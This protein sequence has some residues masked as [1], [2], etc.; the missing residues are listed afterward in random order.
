ML[1]HRQDDGLFLDRTRPTRHGAS[2][3]PKPTA[4]RTVDWVLCCCLPLRHVVVPI[5]SASWRPQAP[6][7]TEIS[8]GG[9]PHRIV[10]SPFGQRFHLEESS[11]GSSPAPVPHRRTSKTPSNGRLP[12]PGPTSD[13]LGGPRLGWHPLSCVRYGRA[14]TARRP[15][16]CLSSGG[17]VGR[18][19]RP[20]YGGRHICLGARVGPPCK[21][22][23]A[24]GRAAER[25]AERAVA[26]CRPPLPRAC[27]C[28]CSVPDAA[29]P[30]SPQSAKPAVCTAP[31]RPPRAATLTPPACPSESLRS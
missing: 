11:I 29:V 6:L 14:P 27:A 4:L 25:A 28:V 7:W 10:S 22:S 3:T 1:F 18:P 5:D 26:A 9:E 30:V 31:S 24:R 17:G 23:R 20:L 21:Q 2:P 12:L 16:Q 8:S 19:R 13:Q 15:P